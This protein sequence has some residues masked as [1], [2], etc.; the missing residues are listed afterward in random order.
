M[1]PLYLDRET[2]ELFEEFK[3][4]NES[5]LEALKRLLKVA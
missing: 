3:K 1:Y 2:T 5:D 4:P